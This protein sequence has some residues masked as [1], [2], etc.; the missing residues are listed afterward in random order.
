MKKFRLSGL[1]V[2]IAFVT[3]AFLAGPGVTSSAA[4]T[5]ASLYSQ[6]CQAC[7][8]ASGKQGATAA[9]ISSAISG[10]AGGMGYLSSL[11]TTQVQDIASY[12]GDN[13]TTTSTT[14]TGTTT[15]GTTTTDTT[16]TG[17]SLLGTTT[18][19]TY[20]AA[21]FDIS[22][23]TLNIPTV[24]VGSATNV[25]SLL[26][27]YYGACDVFSACFK[28]KSSTKK[29][30][31]VR[32]TGIRKDD[33]GGDDGG[34]D[35]GG[36]GWD[37]DGGSY[38]NNYSNNTGNSSTG[39]G[40]LYSQYCASCHGSSSRLRGTS[41]SKISK[42]IS[43]NKGGM[44][45]L[46]NLTS[47]QI[48][49]IA[50][51]IN[52]VSTTTTTTGNTTTTDSYAQKC[53]GCHGDSKRGSSQSAINSAIANNTGGMGYLGSYTITTG[54]T[55]TTTTGSTTTDTTTTTAATS[56]SPATYDINTGLVS[57]PVVTI[58]DSKNST[59]DPDLAGKQYA[60]E[61]EYYGTCGLFTCFKIKT[62]T[63]KQLI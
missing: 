43:R 31:S 37:D 44:G 35:D 42:A 3:A 29:N 27:E 28:L 13:T 23:N 53:Y 50:D 26:L 61:L 1:L 52:G 7:H 20:S 34:D 41:A 25:Y 55:G 17:L 18:T 24:L 56:S 16:T 9:R 19:Q 58:T 36:D 60:I 21:T 59:I 30:S 6:Y 22:T 11:T 62:V 5:G 15:T 38:N 39:T 45:Y 51:T 8:G 47:S 2:F 12:L 33:D 46:S 54:T 63:E 10:N 40:S 48:Q 57:I 49:T 14:T 32:K 4:A